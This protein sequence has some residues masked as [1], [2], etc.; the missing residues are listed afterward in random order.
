MYGP[1]QNRATLV[2]EDDHNRSLQQDIDQVKSKFTLRL[3]ILME[4][5]L[6]QFSGIVPVFALR[7]PRVR[8]TSVHADLV[9]CHH[10]HPVAGG[11][12]D[13]DRGD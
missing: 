8:Q 11:E 3:S 13:D 1:Q 6:G 2:M 10:V 7:H 9:R 12:G 4:F 5:N